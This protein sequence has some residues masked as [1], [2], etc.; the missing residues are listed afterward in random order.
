M[1]TLARRHALFYFSFYF[2]CS[3]SGVGSRALLLGRSVF[4]LG[5]LLFQCALRCYHA[6]LNP[7]RKTR[8]QCESVLS[9]SALHNRGRSCLI[10]FSPPPHRA[11][12]SQP[13]RSG[14]ITCRPLISV[15]HIGLSWHQ[16][17]TLSLVSRRLNYPIHDYEP[18]S[19]K[20]MR[21]NNPVIIL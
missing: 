19:L 12:E 7:Q 2:F 18:M 13:S 14:R 4:L 21:Y 5:A 1:K 15:Q 20:R 3:P 10:R 17:D 11:R 9:V 6:L 16:P 8:T